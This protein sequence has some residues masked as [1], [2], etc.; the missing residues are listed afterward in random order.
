MITAKEFCKWLME[1]PNAEI[2]LTC[3]GSGWLEPNK[4]LFENTCVKSDNLIVL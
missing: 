3:G 4:T 1:H 2:K